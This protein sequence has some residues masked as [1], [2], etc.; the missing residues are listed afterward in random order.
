MEEEF[1]ISD[2]K[3]HAKRLGRELVMQF[4]FQ[5]DVAREEFRQSRWESFMLQAAQT[6]ALRDNRYARKGREYAEKLL[7]GI[8]E[9]QAEIDAAILAHAENWEWDRLAVVDR[10]VM[11]VAVFEMLCMPEVPP[12]VSINE[13]VEIA[14]DYSGEKAGNFINGVLNG[15]KDTLSRPARK[16]VKEL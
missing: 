1:E 16:A 12:V 3:L 8:R 4:L 2:G 13:A 6:H 11:R 10:N 14:R 15:I 9:R 7:N 5:C